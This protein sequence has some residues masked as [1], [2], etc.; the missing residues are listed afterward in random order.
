MMIDTLEKIERRYE[1]L[2]QLMMQ[3][4]VASDREALQAY[5]REHSSLLGTVHK[6]AEY[7]AVMKNL[8][9]AEEMLHEDGIDSD[10][11]QLVEEEVRS[12]RE[13]RDSLLEEI[14]VSL[15]PQDPDEERNC[16]VEIRAGAGGDEAALFAADLYRMYSR[17]AERKRWRTELIQGMGR[18]GDEFIIILDIAKVFSSEDLA[19]VAA[20]S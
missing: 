10:M 18:R 5:A 2:N 13:C 8:A 1:E 16:I 14:K 17:Y 15:V 3:P 20:Q 11:R 4:E 12:L 9:E 6:Y 7:K 19:L